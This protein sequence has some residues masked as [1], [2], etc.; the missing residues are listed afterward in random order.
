MKRRH[1]WKVALGL[2][3]LSS[4]GKDKASDPEYP[5]FSG[6]YDASIKNCGNSGCHEASATSDGVEH[7]PD[8]SSIKAAYAAL[9]G[10]KASAYAE[11]K[12]A[13]GGCAAAT[14]V[15]A[16]SP[17]TSLALAAVKESYANNFATAT[18]LSDCVPSYSVHQV[19]NAIPSDIASLE[20]WIKDGAKK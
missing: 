9:V 2:L 17:T 12:A 18:G 16:G 6:V 10:K 20:Q 19:D 7:G 1:A 5:N 3:I 11:W 14:L 15:V 13:S 4:C 8:L